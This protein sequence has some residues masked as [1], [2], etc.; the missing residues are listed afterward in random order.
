[1]CIRKTTL[2]LCCIFFIQIAAHACS[3]SG[4]PTFCG[5]LNG[6]GWDHSHVLEATKL[7]DTLHGM[8]VLPEKVYIEDSNEIV[9]NEPLLI[10][11]DPGFLCREYT[12]Q[13]EVGEKLVLAIKTMDYA[14]YDHEEIGD[15]TLSLCGLHHLRIVDGM[16]QGRITGDD[17]SMTHEDFE[18]YM[19]T[20]AY[21]NYCPE[22]VYSNTTINELNVVKIFPNP[23]SGELTIINELGDGKIE[24]MVIYSNKG[25]LVNINTASRKGKTA[26]MDLGGLASGIYF[27]Q[28]RMQGRMIN[29]KIVVE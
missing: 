6:N 5:V 25:H 28:I 17:Q 4:P 29:K 18:V 10:W 26:T 7:K 2:I 13:F 8:I 19:E 22:L 14:E 23:T 21:T 1:M 15:F 12:S 20:E 3:C 24:E 16:V 9:L 27:M 11:G